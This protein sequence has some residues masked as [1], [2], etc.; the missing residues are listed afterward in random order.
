MNVL[1]R[2]ILFW[3]K[4]RADAS[5]F[6]AVLPRIRAIREECDW[7]PL[8]STSAT[9]RRRELVE[10][11]RPRIIYRPVPYERGLKLHLPLRGTWWVRLAFAI[12]VLCASALIAFIWGLALT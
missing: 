3:R 1:G 7:Q 6:A 11:A 9:E 12:A 5:R 8:T 2:D 4:P 10:D